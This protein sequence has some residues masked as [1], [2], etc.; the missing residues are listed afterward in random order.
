M[1]KNSERELLDNLK[2]IVF[3]ENFHNKNVEKYF[4][5]FKKVLSEL[6]NKINDGNYKNVLAKIKDVN[7]EKKIYKYLQFVTELI[8]GKY[9]INTFN[10]SFKMEVKLLKN[11]NINTDV[12]FQVVYNKVIYNVEVKCPHYE[13]R[14]LFNSDK[15]NLK[16]SFLTK[17]NTFDDYEQCKNVIEKEIFEELIIKTNLDGVS[18]A[19]LEYNKVKDF[20]ISAQEKFSGEGNENE[21]NIL[22]IGLD[23]SED[24]GEWHTYFTDIGYGFFT[25]KSDVPHIMFNK[26]DL[27]VLSNVVAGHRNFKK[28]DD[29]ACWDINSYFN[30][31]LVNPY[32]LKNKVITEN[33][34]HQVLYSGFKKGK[35]FKNQT[36]LNLRSLVIS[37]FKESGQIIDAKSLKERTNFIIEEYYKRPILYSLLV[38]FLEE[39]QVQKIINPSD[40]KKQY[41]YINKV[42]P[43]ST[44]QFDNFS[45]KRRS[46]S[47]KNMHFID[48][49][50]DYYGLL[51]NKED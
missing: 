32:S 12:D 6:K 19:K 26:V 17:G 33:E 27:V 8:V 15:G 35:I 40:L 10:E 34:L 38:E 44:M 39:P 29:F 49:I 2:K 11:K 31:F 14:D 5:E 4:L 22:F 3:K 36:Y 9:L 21:F 13:K 51:I 20:L 25:Y 41:E 50:S 24:I 18:Y 30:Y 7:A 47:I 1:D 42:I 43:T 46:D 48:Y 28:L 37:S 16:V 45:N 23:S